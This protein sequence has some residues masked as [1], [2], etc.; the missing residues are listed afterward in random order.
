MGSASRCNTCVLVR[1][2][3]IRARCVLM[4]ISLSAR[5]TANILAVQGLKKK[6]LWKI[7]HT[8]SYRTYERRVYQNLAVQEK[9]GKIWKMIQ[10]HS[11]EPWIGSHHGIVASQ[12]IVLDNFGHHHQ[13]FASAVS[14]PSDYRIPV[15]GGGM[16]W[17]GGHYCC[18]RKQS[19]LF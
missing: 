3:D 17:V 1:M 8:C 14:P 19:L 16:A 7:I 10:T 2:Y 11:P 4:R 15:W 13:N 12:G 18:R 6:L 5:P 9:G